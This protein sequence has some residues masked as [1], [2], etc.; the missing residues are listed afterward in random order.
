MNLPIENADYFIYYVNLPPKIF[1]FVALNPD[2]TYSIYLD[3]R[4]S[5]DQ[6]LDDYIHELWHI[7]RGDF[8]N[9]IPVYIIEGRA[10]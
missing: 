1:A 4:R 8:Y 2:D 7:I 9:G 5:Y 6:L 3:P 10:A